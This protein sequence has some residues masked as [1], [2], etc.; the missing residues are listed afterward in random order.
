MSLREIHRPNWGWLLA[1][2]RRAKLPGSLL[3]DTLT[4]ARVAV[5]FVRAVFQS[6]WRAL[7]KMCSPPHMLSSWLLESPKR[8]RVRS[9][10]GRVLKLLDWCV[11]VGAFQRVTPAGAVV[12]RAGRFHW[13]TVLG[14]GL[15]LRT[16]LL[17]TR[18]LNTN[19]NIT[20]IIS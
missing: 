1:P 6:L 8:T 7:G 17:S 13:L 20:S 4:S 5:S 18:E 3:G 19:I 11:C 14:L 2:S 15:V 12:R 10:P 16:R 9:R